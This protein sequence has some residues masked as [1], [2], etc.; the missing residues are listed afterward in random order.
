MN[1][2]WIQSHRTTIAVAALRIERVW[3]IAR[4][5]WRGAI[6]KTH[7]IRHD[8]G[9]N[10]SLCTMTAHFRES[11]L[12][13]HCCSPCLVGY[14]P[15]HLKKN[16]NHIINSI[17][18]SSL[19]VTQQKRVSRPINELGEVSVNGRE[20]GKTRCLTSVKIVLEFVRPL[21]ER[22]ALHPNVVVWDIVLSSRMFQKGTWQSTGDGCGYNEISSVSEIAPVSWKQWLT[23]TFSRIS[24]SC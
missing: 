20:V 1:N 15:F 2:E 23:R 21:M 14:A 6:I 22:E 13:L 16:Q 12:M 3:R 24:S 9:N 5:Q 18:H 17:S 7:K 19:D 8:F 10:R 4:T 11:T